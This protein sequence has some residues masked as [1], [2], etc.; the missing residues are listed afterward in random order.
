MATPSPNCHKI[1]KATYFNT[2]HLLEYI[3]VLNMVAKISQE[4]K[5]M[6]Y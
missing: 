2:L 1:D 3:N 6:I 5:I 4:R